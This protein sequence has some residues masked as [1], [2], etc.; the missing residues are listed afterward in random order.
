MRSAF[1]CTICDYN[2]HF[3]IDTKKEKIIMND[4][5]CEMIADSSINFS[6]LMN[7]KILPF[8]LRLMKVL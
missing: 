6:Y 3:Y 8:Y 2:N 7:Y 5:T 1:Y 4:A